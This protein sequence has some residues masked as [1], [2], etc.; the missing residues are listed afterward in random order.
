MDAT[1][2]DKWG[3]VTQVNFSS[4]N[5]N[6]ASVSPASDTTANPYR[7]VVTGNSSDN[8]AI[9]RAQ[10]VMNAAVRCEATTTV[11]V[12]QPG[13]WWQVKDSDVFSKGNITSLIP[14]TCITPNCQ[15]T[16]DLDGRGGYPGIPIYSELLVLGSWGT[17]SSTG[18]HI[19]TGVVGFLEILL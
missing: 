1:I 5:V 16:F 6:V 8:S 2:T 15:S 4:S 10:V 12:T 18:W 19:Q 17:T 11:T 7:T 9:L 3:E 13:P 14:I